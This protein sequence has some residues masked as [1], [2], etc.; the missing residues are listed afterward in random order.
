MTSG[1]R[2]FI[3]QHYVLLDRLLLTDAE[4][5]NPTWESS[6]DFVSD[7]RE[8]VRPAVFILE[9]SAWGPGDQHT[10]PSISFVEEVI[11]RA[12]L[13][14][15]QRSIVSF[16]FRVGRSDFNRLIF[17]PSIRLLSVGIAPTVSA[18]VTVA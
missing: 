15:L 6:R 3:P 13:V 9:A 10:S 7:L 18:V 11:I 1:A 17:A 8:R 5:D 12:F 16:K 14:K 4:L 2:L